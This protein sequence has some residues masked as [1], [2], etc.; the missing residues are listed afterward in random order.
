SSHGDRSDVRDGRAP[1]FTSR[2]RMD[3][4]LAGPRTAADRYL[5]LLSAALLGYAVLGKGFAYIGF[6]PLYAG[7]IAPLAGSV[8]LLLTAL[9]IAT[10]GTLGSVLLAANIAWTLLRTLPFV[11]SYGFDALRDSVVVMYGG[12]AFVV[13]AILLEDGRRV[14]T[15]VRYYGTFV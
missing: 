4:A 13:I 12:F 14:N 15:L 2:A 8:V 9:I 6:P 5:I 10:L 3:H 11:Q 1:L 7:E